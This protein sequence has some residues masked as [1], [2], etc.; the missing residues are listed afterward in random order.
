MQ[1]R[2]KKV[3]PRARLPEYKT[4]GASGADIFALLDRMI[5]VPPLGACQIRTGLAFEI[6]EGYELQIRTRSGL[7][8]KLGIVV[9]NSPGTVDADYRGEVSVL[10]SNLGDNIV[11]IQHGDR[12]AQ[13]VLQKVERCEWEVT[14]SLSETERGDKGFGSTGTK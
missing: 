11:R 8:S 4:K 12:I 3:D 13:C 2:A 14:D 6:P 10:I 5:S 7:A 9:L 1:V